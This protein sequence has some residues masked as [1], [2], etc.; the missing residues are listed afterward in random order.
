MSQPLRK[1]SSFSGTVSDEAGDE[2]LTKSHSV[3][4]L[5]VDA[6][7]VTTLDVEVQGSPE[8]QSWA[9]LSRPNTPNS[10]QVTDSDLDANGNYYIAS[11]NFAVELIRPYVNDLDA[12]SLDVYLFLSG[13]GGR[14]VQFNRSLSLST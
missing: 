7:G 11:H 13:K 3:I 5:F 2:F 14:G 9:A 6:E 10:F 8:G 4:G 12:D 1:K